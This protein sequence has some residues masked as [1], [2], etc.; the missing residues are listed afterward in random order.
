M[1]LPVFYYEC[2]QSVNE[3]QD[4]HF[5]C[6]TSPT[7]W[8]RRNLQ[9]V[10]STLETVFFF[11]MMI[12]WWHSQLPKSHTRSYM[13]VASTIHLNIACIHLS[14][15]LL[16]QVTLCSCSTSSVWLFVFWN[17]HGPVTFWGYLKVGNP[18]GI[19]ISYWPNIWTTMYLP[20]PLQT[21]ME[22][23]I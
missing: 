9:S 1:A 7:S 22:S 11:S 21:W 12:I 5:N 6:A 2:I 8:S 16:N 23:S 14:I 3:E 19:C 13:L 17:Y 15:H 18:L 4:Y 20:P 10:N